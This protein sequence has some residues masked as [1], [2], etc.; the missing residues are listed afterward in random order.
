[1]ILIFNE[2]ST[3]LKIQDLQEDE[4]KKK[5]SSTFDKINPSSEPIKQAVIIYEL[6]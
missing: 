2:W 6:I 3:V 5:V 4:L 1:L